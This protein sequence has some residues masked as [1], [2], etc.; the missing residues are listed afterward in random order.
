MN[1]D[2]KFFSKW[3]WIG[4]MGEDSN[5]YQC[6]IWQYHFISMTDLQ[7]KYVFDLISFA[8]RSSQKFR[9]IFIL[10]SL[11]NHVQ[12]FAIK[13]SATSNKKMK[14]KNLLFLMPRWIV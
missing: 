7:H 4:L 6:V 9:S 8:Q 11:R 3:G 1:V 5:K 10:S 14:E 12:P 13:L 2:Y